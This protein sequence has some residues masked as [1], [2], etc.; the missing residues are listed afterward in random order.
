[1]LTEEVAAVADAFDAA[2]VVLVACV[3]AAAAVAEPAVVAADVVAGLDTTFIA[4]PRPRVLARPTLSDAARA[5]LL[6]AGWGLRFL[7][8]SATYGHEVSQT[9]GAGESQV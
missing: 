6:E 5:R 1:V 7:V 2:V 4:M 3:A 8:M 9:S